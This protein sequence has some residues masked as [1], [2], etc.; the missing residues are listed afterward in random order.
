M[1]QLGE[2]EAKVM[3]RIWADE[4]PVLV[5]EILEELQGQRS[6]AYTTVMTVMDNL[7]RKGLLRRVREGRAYRYSAVQTKE[8]Y[9]AKLMEEVLATSTDRSA[10]LMHF[11]E[12]MAQDDLQQLKS[13]VAKARRSRSRGARP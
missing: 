2:L 11:L 10:T 8:A 4:R 13:A 12:H 6:L 9:T 7:H 1:R 3:D 5:R